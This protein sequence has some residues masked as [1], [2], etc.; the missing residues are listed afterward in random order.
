MLS[1]TIIAIG[2][3]LGLALAAWGEGAPKLVDPHTTGS[4]LLLYRPGLLTYDNYGIEGYRPWP[5]NV[6]TRTANPVYDEFGQFLV[7]GVEV[8]RMQETRRLEKNP[9][10]AFFEGSNH[11]KPAN[12]D[13]Y[14]NR[15]MVADDS[16]NAW[17]TRFIIGDRI[18]THFSPLYLD[19]AA[20][21][22]IRWDLAN[23]TQAFSVVSS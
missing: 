18:R 3:L 20:L 13:S 5:R 19:L 7:N 17:H 12:Y 22:G 4:R 11:L 23:E 16:Y 6:L 1:S 9:V 15:L 14:V 10:S 21:N 2:S 8:Y